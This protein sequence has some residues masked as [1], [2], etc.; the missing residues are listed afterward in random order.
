MPPSK[1]SS[2]ANNAQDVLQ[3]LWE[4]YRARTAQRTKLLDLF[5]A[6]LVVVG[7]LQFVY[8]VVAGNYVGFSFSFFLSLSLFIPYAPWDGGFGGLFGGGGGCF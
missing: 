4:R 5:M 2:S 1:S 7:G 6:F 3:D 8:C